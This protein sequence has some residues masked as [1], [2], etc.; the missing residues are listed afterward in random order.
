MSMLLHLIGPF[1]YYLQ[2]LFD[3]D[4]HTKIKWGFLVCCANFFLCGKSDSNAKKDRPVFLPQM[5]LSSYTNDVLSLSFI[6]GQ[7]RYTIKGSNQTLT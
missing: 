7:F 4:T 5:F 3:R 6:K 1:S 2:I